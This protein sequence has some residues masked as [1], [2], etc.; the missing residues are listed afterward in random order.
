MP[1]LVGVMQ[2]FLRGDG[3]SKRDL[4]LPRGSLCA[5]A[6]G[7]ARA[8]L[9]RWIRAEPTRSLLAHANS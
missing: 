1:L 6:A 3:W 9:A 5:S 7:A 4:R 8:R 2:G